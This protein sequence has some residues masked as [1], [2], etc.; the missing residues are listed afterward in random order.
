MK[1][2]PLL[3]LLVFATP[4]YAITWKEFWEP[5]KSNSWYENN[6][7]NYPVYRRPTRSFERCQREVYREEYVPGDL[8]SPGYVRRW[9]DVQDIPCR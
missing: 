4:S 6:Y 8:Y 2:L 7:Y 1:F 3:S 9:R 5:F